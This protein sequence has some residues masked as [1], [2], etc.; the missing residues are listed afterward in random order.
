[1]PDGSPHVVQTWVDHDGDLVLI[2][3]IV[4]SQKHKNAQRSPMVALDVSDHQ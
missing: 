3:T 4:G 2:N 1:M